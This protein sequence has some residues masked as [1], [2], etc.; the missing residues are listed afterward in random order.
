[1]RAPF[2]SSGLTD[3]CSPGCTVVSVVPIWKVASKCDCPDSPAGSESPGENV[4]SPKL[5]LVTASER[6]SACAPK[7]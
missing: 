3:R 7:P 4:W 2:P 6:R 1:M 5:P